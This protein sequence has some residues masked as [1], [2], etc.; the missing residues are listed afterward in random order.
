MT[1]NNAAKHD[2]HCIYIMQVE[3]P[4]K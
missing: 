4:W 3:G 2:Q 1:G